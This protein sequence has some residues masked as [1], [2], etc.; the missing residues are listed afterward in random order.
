MQGLREASLRGR[1][2]PCLD[3]GSVAPRL[4]SWNESESGSKR[5]ERL[6]LHRMVLGGVLADLPREG[7][8]AES[9]TCQ[10]MS[11]ML[12]GQGP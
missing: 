9:Y 1:L 5:R 12:D 8:W 10:P 6:F 4:E 3:S 11:Q 2:Q 7:G